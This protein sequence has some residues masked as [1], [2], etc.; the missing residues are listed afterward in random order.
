MSEPLPVDIGAFGVV[1]KLQRTEG[2][3]AATIVSPTLV[4]ELFDPASRAVEEAG[5]EIVSADDE[6]IEFELFLAS[7]Q[8]DSGLLRAAQTTCEGQ[9]LVELTLSSTT[10][11]T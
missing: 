3:L 10:P 4:S 2:F 11:A 5:Y 9:T 7:G 8:E 1:T 6:G